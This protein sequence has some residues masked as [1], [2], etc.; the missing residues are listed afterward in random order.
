MACCQ[1]QPPRSCRGS[2][3]ISAKEAEESIFWGKEKAKRRAHKVWAG[4]ESAE[5]ARPTTVPR[6]W[7]VSTVWIK[8]VPTCTKVSCILSTLPCFLYLIVISVSDANSSM[9]KSSKKIYAQRDC[10]H[11]ELIKPWCLPTSLK[12]AAGTGYQ[13]IYR[14][15]L[16]AEWIQIQTFSFDAGCRFLWLSNM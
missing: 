8:P 1:D 9:V 12:D 4:W 15:S 7:K 16:S 2:T 10:K 11:C 3:S 13:S 5:E 14:G 6:F